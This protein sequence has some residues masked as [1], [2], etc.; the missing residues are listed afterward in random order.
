[1]NN[2][3][4]LGQLRDLVSGTPSYEHPFLHYLPQTVDKKEFSHLNPLHLYKFAQ[5][6]LKHDQPVVVHDAMKILNQMINPHTGTLIEPTPSMFFD[7]ST[8]F[9]KSLGTRKSISDVITHIINK[10]V[11]SLSLQTN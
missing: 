5:I 1:M 7:N 6:A 2:S 10:V 4:I 8:F 9:W 11:F 3:D